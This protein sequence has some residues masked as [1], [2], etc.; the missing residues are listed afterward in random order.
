MDE[1]LNR[2][3]TQIVN[4]L[5]ILLFAVALFMFVWGVYDLYIAKGGDQDRAQGSRH[6][7]AG[8]IGMVI[9]IGVFAIMSFTLNT[10]NRL[11]KSNIQP[12]STILR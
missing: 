9:M 10:V 4:P 2:I 5:V 7:L 6:I 11:F 8:I 1:V 12:P 3:V